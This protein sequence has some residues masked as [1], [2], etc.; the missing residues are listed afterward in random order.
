[1]ELNL[2]QFENLELFSAIDQAIFS[3]EIDATYV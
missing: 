3:P 1:M 2:T